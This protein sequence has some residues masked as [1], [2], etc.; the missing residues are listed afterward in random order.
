MLETHGVA[1]REQVTTLQNL[2]RQVM[3]LV[4]LLSERVARTLATNT[5]R[6]PKETINIVSSRSGHILEDPRANQ[7]DK[8]IERQVEIVE[9]QKIDNI[10]EG[11]WMVD[12]GL[13]KKGKTRAQKNQKDEN[14]IN[15]ETEESKYMHALRFPQK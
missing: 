8:M 7:K 3:Q 10:Q 11:A 14:A 1:I 4:N 15:E 2:E 9:E 13:K 5:T 6:N 12:D